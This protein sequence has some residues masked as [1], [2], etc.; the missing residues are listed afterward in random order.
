MDYEKLEIRPAEGKLG[1]MLVGLGAVSTTFVA[2][3]EMIRKGLAKPIGCQAWMG[4]A[5]LGKR[6]DNRFAKLHELVPLAEPED[7]VFAAWDIFP[8]NAYEAALKA[9]V[10]DNADLVQVRDELHG[11]TPLAGAFDPAYVKKLEGTHVKSGTRRE[12]VEAL[13]EDIRAF[14]KG[15]D[16]AVMVWA[17]STEVYREPGPVHLSLDAFEAGLDQDDHSI[18]PSQLYAYAAL[19]EGVPFANGAPNLTVDVAAMI[20]LANRGGVPISGKDFKT[21]QTLMK[22]IVAPGLKNRL[23]GVNGWFSTNILGNRDGEVLDDPEAFKSKEVSKAGVLDTIFQTETYPELYGDLYHKIRINYYPPRGDAKEG[24]DNIDLFGWLGYPCS[25]TSPS[26][27]AGR[28]SRSGSRSS[29]S[30]RR[31]PRA[32]T[33]S[34]I[35][36]SRR[37][38]SRTRCAAWPASR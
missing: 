22:T 12:M 14:K 4:T 28:A 36:I 30:R 17:A 38:S 32:S 34:T 18:A 24:W 3:V 27:R 23:L 21:G 37:S 29:T 9:G 11:L 13:R 15:V 8:D 10:L 26:A 6:T 2:G 31:P 1:V 16:R 20:E 19:I 33:R 7:L 5:R 25:W 35:F